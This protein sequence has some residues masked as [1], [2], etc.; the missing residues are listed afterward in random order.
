MLFFQRVAAPFR[1]NKADM[2]KSEISQRLTPRP[3]DDDDEPSAKAD[4][5]FGAL[6]GAS[7]GMTLAI[8]MGGQSTLALPA[9]GL[10]GPPA[11]WVIGALIGA[12]GGSFLSVLI[13]WEL[14][15]DDDSLLA[16]DTNSVN[17]APR[18]SSQQD[19]VP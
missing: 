7:I 6:L 11:A 15:G 9:L 14:G 13:G 4:A 12:A 18:S 19:L 2:Y 5:L 17:E 1:N 8:S 3:L 16:D 10:S